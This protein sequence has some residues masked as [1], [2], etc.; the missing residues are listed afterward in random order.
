[1]IDDRLGARIDF[2]LTLDIA[3]EDDFVRDLE[4]SFET[5]SINVRAEAHFANVGNPSIDE[6][7]LAE[8]LEDAEMD[9]FNN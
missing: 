5:D 2:A 9:S 6:D 7:A 3:I 1:M 4:F 8:L